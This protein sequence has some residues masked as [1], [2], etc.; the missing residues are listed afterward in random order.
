MLLVC[1]ERQEKARKREPNTSATHMTLHNCC[2]AYMYIY[3][4]VT[5]LQMK[6]KGVSHHFVFGSSVISVLPP[7][8]THS[9]QPCLCLCVCVSVCVCVCVCA[10]MS[11]SVYVSVSTD[12][13]HCKSSWPKSKCKMQCHIYLSVHVSTSF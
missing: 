13:L 4:Y 7:V 11:L 6:T 9:L 5:L 2:C 1:G 8:H 3:Q 12:S 10:Y